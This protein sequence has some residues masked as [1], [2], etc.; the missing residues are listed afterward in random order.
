MVIE[1][2]VCHDHL[3]TRNYMVSRMG[4]CLLTSRETPD[5]AELEN[6]N[7]RSLEDIGLEVH[8]RDFGTLKPF[9]IP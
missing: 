4:R 6:L 3:S 8:K 2:E 7:D 9:W 1:V 5:S